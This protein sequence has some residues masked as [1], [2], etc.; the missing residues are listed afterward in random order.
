[1]LIQRAIRREVLEQPPLAR[2][3]PVELPRPRRPAPPLPQKLKKKQ[4]QKSQ[5]QRR[6]AFVLDVGR[7]LQRRNLRHRFAAPPEPL[8]PRRPR[9][10]LDR[11]RIQVNEILVV[12][13]I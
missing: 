7:L 12:D 5:L 10:V 4:L 8:R 9:K 11:L 3:E 2:D 13:A 1:M 6:Y